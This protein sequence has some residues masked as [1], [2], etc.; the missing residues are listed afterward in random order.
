MLNKEAVLAV[1]RVFCINNGYSVEKLESEF[2][3]SNDRFAVFTHSRPGVIP[4]GLYNDIETQRLP[5]LWVNNDNGDLVIET[6]PY[7]K[8][9]LN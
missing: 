9:Y 1:A 3:Q 8:I 4:N 7:T 2:Y 5:T 6:T